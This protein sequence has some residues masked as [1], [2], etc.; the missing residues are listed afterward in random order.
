VPGEWHFQHL[1][2]PEAGGTGLILTEAS[3]VVPEGRISPW[4]L[5]SGTT[6]R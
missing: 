5:G 1:S 3:A 2:S 6:A 4:D